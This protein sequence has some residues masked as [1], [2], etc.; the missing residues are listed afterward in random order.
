MTPSN[1]DMAIALDIVQRFLK[2]STGESRLHMD[3]DGNQRALV[4]DIAEALKYE[5]VHAR[6]AGRAE[7]KR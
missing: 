7:R 3:M 1:G 4:N 5:R 6:R 2:L